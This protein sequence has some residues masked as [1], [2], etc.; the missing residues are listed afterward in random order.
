MIRVPLMIRA[1]NLSSGVVDRPVQLLDLAPTVLE[2][3]DV[4]APP[5][6]KGR[7]LVQGGS[8]KAIVAA[9]FS[10]GPLRWMWRRGHYKVVVRMEHQQAVT[11]EFLK[12]YEEADPLPTGFFAYDLSLDPEELHPGAIP[13]EVLGSVVADF[14]SSAGRLVPGLQIMSVGSD[15]GS[16]VELA[17]DEGGGVKQI[18][19][20]G[21]VTVEQA[22]T[23]I[24]LVTGPAGPFFAVSLAAQ[25][26]FTPGRARP[27]WRIGGYAD[28]SVIAGASGAVDSDNSPG[29]F[30]WWN[31][32]RDLVV[33]SHDETMDRLRALGYVQ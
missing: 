19:A 18:W 25:A 12:P 14:A 30:A 20:T 24:R 17:L 4:P 7:S 11:G 32:E 26:G 28:P 9:T 10:A 2:L 16:E 15:F 6:M 8:E 5:S 13:S 23:S 22:G 29:T 33:G 3:L 31:P 1:P 21:P 27:P